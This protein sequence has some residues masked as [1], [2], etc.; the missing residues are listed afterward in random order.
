MTKFITAI[1]TA[2]LKY[3]EAHPHQF[4]EASQILGPVTGKILTLEMLCATDQSILEKMNDCAPRL[5]N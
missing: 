3:A 2:I 4:H 1:I 5:P